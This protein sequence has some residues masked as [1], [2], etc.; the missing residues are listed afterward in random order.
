MTLKELFT[1]SKAVIL[2]QLDPE[3]SSKLG[4]INKGYK[5]EKIDIRV[6][7]FPKNDGYLLE[8]SIDEKSPTSISQVFFISIFINS[9]LQDI[10]LLYDRKTYLYDQGRWETYMDDL[11]RE[12]EINES[13]IQILIS[14]IEEWKPIYK[15]RKSKSPM[16]IAFLASKS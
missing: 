15:L 1:L 7:Q 14:A 3:P 6:A 11:I 2:S 9:Q 13:A 12:N 4:V 8:I 16:E 5:D 10:H